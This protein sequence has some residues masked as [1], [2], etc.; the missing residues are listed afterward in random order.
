MAL[1]IFFL[2]FAALLIVAFTSGNDELDAG[3]QVEHGEGATDLIWPVASIQPP[4]LAPAAS[5]RI[6]PDND[7]VAGDFAHPL[8][9]WGAHEAFEPEWTIINPSTG[10]PMV[11]GMGG[12]DV[13][14]NLWGAMPNWHAGSSLVFPSH[15]PDLRDTM[16]SNDPMSIAHQWAGSHDW[17]DPRPDDYASSQDWMG[18][19]SSSDDLSR[20]GS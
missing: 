12:V 13:A 10:L 3:G 2:L 7:D 6:W 11:G 14:G 19:L 15:F 16:D 8:S 17:H 4:H 9:R 18:G 20:W 5:R 1:V